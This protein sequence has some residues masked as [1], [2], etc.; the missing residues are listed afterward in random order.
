[1]IYHPFRHLGLKFLS[2]VIAALLWLSVAGEQVVERSLLAPLELV[3]TP[4]DLELVE[5][6]PQ[7]VSV[8]VRGSSSVLSQIELGSIVAV[9]DAQAARPRRQ[10]FHLTPGDVRAPFGV[11]IMQIAPGTVPLRF[12]RRLVRTVPVEPAQEGT[13]AEGFVI[14]SIAVEPR[15]VAIEGP[16]SAVAA[17]KS[18]A[19][20]SINVQSASG[21]IEEWV[22]IRVDD[23]LV[24]L[25]TPQAARVVVDVR[26]LPAVR[27]LANVPVAARNGRSRPAPSPSP[28][29]VRVEVRGPKALVEGLDAASLAA[30]V[31]LAG[32]KPGRY[33]LPVKVEA[34]P[35][36]EAVRIE[37]AQVT[38]RIK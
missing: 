12:E 11:E 30:F 27:T 29:R 34:P 3:N 20:E 38:I 24:R 7:T 10:Y 14:T 6:P 36:V 15:T 25:V 17:V 13:P 33:N 4:A 32:L 31:E 28:A 8:R 16:E 9:I 23:P 26:P 18:A 22:T 19:T 5:S 1:M 37:P 21:R 2:V 35:G